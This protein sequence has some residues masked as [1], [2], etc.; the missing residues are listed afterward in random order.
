MSPSAFSLTNN[1]CWFSYVQWKVIF[2]KINICFLQIFLT[3]GGCAANN[4]YFMVGQVI[5]CINLFQV[6]LLC[7]V[8]ILYF[9]YIS[10]MLSNG[11]LIDYIFK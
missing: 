11:N 2:L 7:F 1:A 10:W 9:V 6:S 3:K 5:R 8:Y 4:I